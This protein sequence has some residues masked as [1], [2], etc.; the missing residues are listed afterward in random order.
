[1]TNIETYIISDVN[2]DLDTKLY[3][4][5]AKSSLYSFLFLF[6][7]TQ[8]T[9]YDFSLDGSFTELPCGN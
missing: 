4:I 1:M 7:C 5:L 3:V 6:N 9:S 2:N 8:Q